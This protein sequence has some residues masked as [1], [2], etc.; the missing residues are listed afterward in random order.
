MSRARR[1]RERKKKKVHVSVFPP[2]PEPV[3]TCLRCEEYYE[4]CRCVYPLYSTDGK[5]CKG[6]TRAQILEGEYHAAIASIRRGHEY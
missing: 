3:T 4:D 5:T 2:T 6:Y 1:Q